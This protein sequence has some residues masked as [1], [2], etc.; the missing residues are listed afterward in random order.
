MELSD[1]S[2][3]DFNTYKGRHRTITKNGS[4]IFANDGLEIT[5]TEFDITRAMLSPVSGWTL[6]NLE[7]GYRQ[8]VVLELI[9]ET[10]IKTTMQNSNE[11][12][13]QIQLDGVWYD[14]LNMQPWDQAN[15][16]QHTECFVVRCKD[17]NY[18]K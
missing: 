16:L 8:R 17:D 5:Y 13:D 3:I 11:L 4:S 15:F 9:T 2:L 7:E 10:K 1:F 12:C 6:Q 14:L 18:V